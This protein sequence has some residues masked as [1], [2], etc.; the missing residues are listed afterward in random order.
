[1]KRA[2]HIHPSNF[3]LRLLFRLI[4]KLSSDDKRFHTL[5]EW[6]RKWK[7]LWRVDMR[8]SGGKLY[9]FPFLFRE[10][11]INFEHIKVED[12]LRGKV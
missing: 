4:R 7:C 1:V 2:S 8:P 10:T 3:W 11:A 6:T 5:V 12:Q 9:P